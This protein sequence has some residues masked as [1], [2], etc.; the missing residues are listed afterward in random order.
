M[1][2]LATHNPKFWRAYFEIAPGDSGA[3]M[4]YAGMLMGSGQVSRAKTLLELQ[5]YHPG[6]TKA[7]HNAL[8][9]L[10]SLGNQAGSKSNAAV[11]EGVKFFDRG[12]YPAA[13][14]KYRE[15]L[16][17]WPENGRAYYELGYTIRTQDMIAAGV[18][19]EMPSPG[20][21][22]FKANDKD[23]AKVPFSAQA[24]NANAQCRKYSPFM[25]EAYQGDNPTTLQFVKAMG[26][27]IIP[28]LQG[29]AQ[30]TNDAAATDRNLE[31][32]A[33]G[34]QD[35]EQD[36]LALLT[37]QVMVARRQGFLPVDHP[38]I[39]TSLRRLAP[40]A[41]T[42]TTLERLAGPEKIAFYQIVNQPAAN[43]PTE[44]K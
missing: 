32:L 35:A 42:E 39:V 22:V 29:L 41:D 40:G 5:A 37:R 34:L 21:M 11:D 9:Q 20:K 15:A 2:A 23:E 38:F 36:E 3:V 30:P 27:D 8:G 7:Q 43:P 26:T 16:K 24:K 44:S 31:Q 19:P 12:D 18:K 14:K 33:K 25:Y 17:I 13:E 4:L 1:D 28:A 6:I 10:W